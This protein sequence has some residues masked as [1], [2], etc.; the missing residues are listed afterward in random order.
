V[1]GPVPLDRGCRVGVRA[2]RVRAKQESVLPGRSHA[3]HTGAPG[4]VWVEAPGPQA[5]VLPRRPHAPLTTQTLGHQASRPGGQELLG[6]GHLEGRGPARARASAHE[7]GLGATLGRGSGP[8][9][10]RTTP[11]AV[12]P[13]E[14]QVWCGHK[15]GARCSRPSNGT[16]SGGPAATLGWCPPAR[17]AADH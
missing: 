5:G 12:A 4:D 16:A 2:R 13:A 15:E 11:P 6:H 9:S 7:P 10:R 14:G 3:Q 17:A 1:L 8:W